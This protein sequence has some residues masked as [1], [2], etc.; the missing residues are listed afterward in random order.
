M[1]KESYMNINVPSSFGSYMDFL[2]QLTRDSCHSGKLKSPGLPLTSLSPI[3]GG[4]KNKES[5]T[6]AVTKGEERLSNCPPPPT[7]W[8]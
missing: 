8:T 4:R 3:V 7:E 6:V 2:R 5:H 1:N